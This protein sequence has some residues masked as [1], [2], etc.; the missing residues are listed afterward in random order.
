MIAFSFAMTKL[1]KVSV[2]RENLPHAS[3][4]LTITVP[5]ELWQD[6]EEEILD[7]LKLSIN[8]PGF[9]KGFAPKN[10]VR[11]QIEEDKLAQE[12]L[13]RL[14]PLSYS[15][16]V[17]KE[18]LKPIGSPQIKITQ[19]EKDKDFVYEAEL[20][21]LPEVKLGNYKNLNIKKPKVSLSDAE[22]NK[23]L[24]LLIKRLSDFKDTNVKVVN[25]N[26]VL[27]NFT[28]K[29]N[30][31]E[32]KDF[33]GEN[34]PIMIGG[35]NV[36]ADFSKQLLGKS[37]ND[38]FT[39]TTTLSKDFNRAGLAGQKVEFQV[40]VKAVQKVIEPTLVEVAKKLGHKNEADLKG[41]ISEYLKMQKEKE[42]EKQ[43]GNDLMEKL[44]QGSKVD[45]SPTLVSQEQERL[46]K[47]ISQDLTMQGES[48][49]SFL[50]K[51]KSSKDEFAKQFKIQAEKNLV[52]SFLLQSIVD[53]EQ[54]KVTT[55]EIDQAIKREK[56]EL[57]IQGHKEEDIEKHL[58]EESHRHG[59]K[60]H[61]RLDKAVALI[62]EANQ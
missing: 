59:L 52:F 27:I 57:K 36:I 48:L 19:F 46:I 60:S 12:V 8:I 39:F 7:N 5:K 44:T 62:K 37:A 25:G 42:A 11:S 40:E 41:K 2:K 50:Q 21:L 16:A 23:E 24:K 54:I 14:L 33:K 45:L 20:A 22:V 53:K 30:G 6:F 49:D 9:R 31:E 17:K 3:A 13:E 38:Q 26:R 34:E 32:I 61:L 28:V 56:M 18:N 43:W 47:Q 15:H 29:K 1:D 58:Q 55:K 10:L 51:T 35:N 4:K